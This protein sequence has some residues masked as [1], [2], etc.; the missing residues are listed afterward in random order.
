MMPAE[1]IGSW[2]NLQETNCAC[3]AVLSRLFGGLHQLR[4]AVLSVPIEHFSQVGRQR[5][6]FSQA[7]DKV[8]SDVR[9]FL[10]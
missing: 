2:S 6:S 8:F 4:Q 9:R 3:R 10:A 1:Y 7:H 5:H